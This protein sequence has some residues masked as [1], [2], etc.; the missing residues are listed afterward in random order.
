MAFGTFIKKSWKKCFQNTHNR[1][2]NLGQNCAIPVSYQL[3][4]INEQLSV[5]NEF[6]THNLIIDN[7][8]CLLRTVSG[9]LDLTC[10][11]RL[12]SFMWIGNAAQRGQEQTAYP[13]L[14]VSESLICFGIVL[15]KITN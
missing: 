7:D 15:G 11:L 14:P 10:P 9:R 1:L 4:V 3:S 12:T 5:I 13:A 8:N 6:A 2:T